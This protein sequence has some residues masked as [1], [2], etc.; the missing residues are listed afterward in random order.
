MPTE[1]GTKSVGKLL[2]QYTIPAIVAMVATSLYNIVDSIYIGQGVG[3]LAI[4]G[5][6]VTFPLMN[7]FSALGTLVGVGSMTMISLTLG[8]GNPAKANKILGNTM[9][10]CV[11]IG[12]SLMVLGLIFIDPMLYLFGASDATIGYARDYMQVILMGTVISYVYFGLN[13]I[14]RTIGHPRRAMMATLLTVGL[15]VI[16]DPIFIF[17]LDMGVRGAAIATVLSQLVSLIWLLRIFINKKEV[18][19]F[20][21]KVFSFDY[22]ITKRSFAIGLSPCLMNLAACFVTVFLNIQLRTYGNQMDIANGGDLAIGAYGIIN[23]IGFVFF[24]IVLGLSHGMQP[25]VSYNYGAK[26]YKRAV[27]ALKLTIFWATIITSIG[28]LISILLPKTIVSAFTSDPTLISLA[29]RGFRIAFAS[30]CIVGAQ[31]II[32][33]FFVCIG[34]PK[35]AIF[36]SLSRQI[37]FLIPCLIVLPLFFGLEGIWWSI[38]V[39]DTISFAVTITMLI[40]TLKNLNSKSQLS[41]L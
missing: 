30:F 12:F 18:L 36:L 32:A 23:R 21:K 15:N 4:S 39:S 20:S 33:H 3:A 11:V 19:S 2:Q 14:L 29:M 7:I 13:S 17:A 9:T 38:P 6:A 34:S 28:F 31:I 35:R 8:Q 1:L 26:Q 22:D 24:M 5:L 25:I 10:L 40:L 41:E 27:K 16:L 37:L